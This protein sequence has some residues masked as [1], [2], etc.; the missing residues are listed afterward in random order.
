MRDNH[1]RLISHKRTE[2]RLYLSFRIGIGK[3]RGLVHD[4]DRRIFEQLCSLK[5]F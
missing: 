2:S 1:Q 3:G 4:D 5:N